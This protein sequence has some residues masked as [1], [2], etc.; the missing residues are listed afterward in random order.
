GKYGCSRSLC[1]RLAVRRLY[2]Q[3]PFVTIANSHCTPCV[4]CTKN[5]YDFNPSVAYLADLYDDDRYYSNYR[6]F[7]AAAMPGFILAYFTL[8]DPTIRDVPAMYLWFA[9]YI[10]VSVGAFFVLDACLKVTTN[11]LTALCGAA[12]LNL[13]YWFGLP[14]W[15]NAVGGLFGVTPPAWLAWLGAGGFVCGERIGVRRA[16]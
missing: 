9:L 16:S 15:F 1:A 12:A 4:G 14:A 8:P 10:L 13:F 11:K 5:C 2:N 3:T 6:K 7:F